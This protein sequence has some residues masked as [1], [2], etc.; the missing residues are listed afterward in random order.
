MWK[1]KEV[2][3]VERSTEREIRG[4]K[5]PS[6]TEGGK[7]MLEQIIIHGLGEECQLK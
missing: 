6:Y 2:R 1:G 5:S 4:F 3:L 7:E